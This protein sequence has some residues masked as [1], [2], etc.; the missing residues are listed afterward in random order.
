[1]YLLCMV[2]LGNLFKFFGSARKLEKLASDSLALHLPE[3]SDSGVRE[4]GR[5]QMP[6]ILQKGGMPPIKICDVAVNRVL[7]KKYKRKSE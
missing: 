5:E 2:L 3:V 4:R 6:P 1:M 7:N